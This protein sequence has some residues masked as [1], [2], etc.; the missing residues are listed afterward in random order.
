MT[1]TTTIPLP[2]EVELRSYCSNGTATIELRFRSNEEASEIINKLKCEISSTTQYET[3][4]KATRYA[5]EDGVRKLALASGRYKSCCVCGMPFSE[6]MICTFC[7][8]QSP[9]VSKN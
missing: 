5:Y 9:H 4:E 7:G 3:I 1:K 6:G 8:E 2:L